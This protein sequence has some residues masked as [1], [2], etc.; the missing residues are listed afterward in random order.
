MSLPGISNFDTQFVNNPRPRPRPAWL[1]ANDMAPTAPS[2]RNTRVIPSFNFPSTNF[3]FRYPLPSEGG[4]SAARRSPELP[5][6]NRSPS[7]AWYS[8]DD[9]KPLDPKGR[10]R[11]IEEVEE[12][13]AKTKARKKTTVTT[14]TKSGAKKP[15]K[16]AAR[17]A[18]KTEKGAKRGRKPGAAGYSEAELMKLLKLAQKYLPIGGAGWDLVMTEYNQWAKKNGY[19]CDRGRKALR[20]KFDAVYHVFMS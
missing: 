1:G 17:P 15:K 3:D 16:A 6:L 19:T 8:D 14:A 13:P 18:V 10:K 5:L 9:G 20:T 4:S 7:P 12:E 11:Q 2:N